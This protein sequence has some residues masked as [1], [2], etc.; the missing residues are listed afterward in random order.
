MGE[1]KGGKTPRVLFS[2]IGQKI[3]RGESVFRK[4]YQ[5][6]QTINKYMTVCQ[7]C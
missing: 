1:S 6:Q 2:A 7:T 4:K 3:D 5:Q